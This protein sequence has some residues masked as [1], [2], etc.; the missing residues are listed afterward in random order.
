MLSNSKFIQNYC[1]KNGLFAFLIE[2]KDLEN[3]KLLEKYTYILSCFLSGDN[4]EPK[5][6]FLK[7]FQG[8]Q[9]L[10]HLLE[11]KGARKTH[12]RVLLIVG[13]LLKY[14]ENTELQEIRQLVWGDFLATGLREDIYQVLDFSEDT[15]IK[16]DLREAVYRLVPL[17]EGTQNAE[18]VIFKLR[19][20]VEDSEILTKERELALLEDCL[21]RVKEVKEIE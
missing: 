5:I 21:E 20:Q 8:L 6:T 17:I 14:E 9:L 11:K 15:G 19:K 7:N 13:E 12:L 16:Q 2:F 4:K 18:E 10:K 3:D 1:L